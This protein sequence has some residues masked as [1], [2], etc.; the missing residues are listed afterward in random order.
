MKDGGRMGPGCSLSVERLTK[1]SCG[2]RSLHSTNVEV[3]VVLTDQTFDSCQSDPLDS[4]IHL[5]HLGPEWFGVLDR[6]LNE[7]WT[8]PSC[9]LVFRP[10]VLMLALDLDVLRGCPSCEG[11]WLGAFR[12]RT[13]SWCGGAPPG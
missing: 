5:L 7:S 12:T 8:C 11:L 13:P 9:E 1:E 4:V 3:P 6:L 2:S 10:T